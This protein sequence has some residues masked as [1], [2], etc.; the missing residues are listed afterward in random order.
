MLCPLRKLVKSAAFEE[1]YE[2][3]CCWWI[4]SSQFIDS[5]AIQ[6]ITLMLMEENK[7]AEP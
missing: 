3:K 6:I 2:E 4:L 5:C 7:D 1:C